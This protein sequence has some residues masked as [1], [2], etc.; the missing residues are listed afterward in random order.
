[1]SKTGVVS[2]LSSPHIWR[3]GD[4]PRSE[5]T[6][7]PTGFDTLDA[8]LPEGGW[9]QQGM[10]ELLCDQIGAGEVSLLMPALAATMRESRSVAW[11]NPPCLPYAPALANSGL[12]LSQLMIVR[13]ESLAE[14][15]WAAEQA[16]RSGALGMVLLW[17]KQHVDYASLRRLHLAAESGNCAAFVYRST[18][19]AVQPSPAPLRVQVDIENNAPQVTIVKRRGMMTSRKFALYPAPVQ[20]LSLKRASAAPPLSTVKPPLPATAKPATRTLSLVAG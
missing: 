4:L 17:L 20:T 2:L 7:I 14:N 10:T 11:I 1:M 19:F 13:A 9:P 18:G 8:E 5:R 15:L 3:V 6:G 12:D 16:L